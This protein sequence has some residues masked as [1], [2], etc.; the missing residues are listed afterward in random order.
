MTTKHTPRR[1]LAPLALA[2]LPGACCA[3]S[4]PPGGPGHQSVAIDNP[5]QARLTARIDVDGD[6]V[7]DVELSLGS[8]STIRRELPCGPWWIDA[9]LAGQRWSLPL[10]LHRAALRP[11]QLL[12]RVAPPPAPLPVP[13]FVWIPAGPGLVGDVLGVGQ[14]D[15]RPAR[16]LD[17]AGFWLAV[18]EVSNADYVRFL[19]ACGATVD[20][21]WLDFT[22][23]K[24]RLRRGADGR[25][26]T[27]APELPVVTVSHAGA[28]AYCAQRTAATGLRHRLPT[29]CEWEKAAR[30]PQS[31]IYAYGDVYRQEAA[32]QQSGSLQ[33]VG[34]HPP[35]GFGLCDMTGNAFEWVADMYARDAWQTGHAPTSGEYRVLRGGSFVLDGIFLRNSLRM[36]LRPSVRADDVGFRVAI[37][38]TE[39]R[40]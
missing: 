21:N 26:A 12:V 30:G 1:R 36:K 28:L 13:D 11:P 7:V 22:S 34:G 2:A 15:E 23:R 20:P 35:V 40:P 25:W 37:D 19:D 24:C 39:E 9:E 33:H 6:G 18:T 32:N 4:W 3:P 17:F 27:D 14:E 29:E 5:Q 38:P 16:I 8:A 31:W 10:P